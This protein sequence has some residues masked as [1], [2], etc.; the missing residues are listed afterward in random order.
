MAF[1]CHPTVL[2]GAQEATHHY[3]LLI[4]LIF[5]R[6]AFLVCGEHKIPTFLSTAAASSYLPPIVTTPEM[7]RTSLHSSIMDQ[8]RIS[9]G[10]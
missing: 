7:I 1:L 6:V 3:L 8:P 4:M 5:L 2:T 9:L 10:S